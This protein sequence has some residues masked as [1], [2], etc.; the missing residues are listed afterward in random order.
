MTVKL[1]KSWIL[2]V[3]QFSIPDSHSRSS[4]VA[5]SYGIDIDEC[6]PNPCKNALNCTDL[7]NDYYCNCT[8]GYTGKNCTIGKFISFDQLTRRLVVW[9]SYSSEPNKMKVKSVN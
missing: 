5:V 3:K 7:V 9:L 6:S 1:P 4:S 2:K 8:A